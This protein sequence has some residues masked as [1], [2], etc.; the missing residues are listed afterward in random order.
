MTR[1]ARIAVWLGVAAAIAAP[2]S[3]AITG[4]GLTASQFAGQ[5]DATLR[6]AGYAF[7]I[8]GVIYAG[9]IGYAVRRMLQGPGAALEA[10]VDL[11]LA[12]ASLGCGLWIVAA[13]LN[14]RWLTVLVIAAAL[15]A[16][17]VGLVRLRRTSRTFTWAERLTVL[18]PLALLAG[19]L[20]VAAVVNLLTVLTAEGLI[21]PASASAAAIAGIVAAGALSL[22]VLRATRLV[23]YTLPVAWGLLGAFMAERGDQ[24][25][26]AYAA[27]AFAGLLPIA[28][29]FI[30]PASV[31]RSA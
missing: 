28:A 13:G 22:A 5:G 7:S 21:G 30:R 8:W 1:A 31:A 6:V 9:L 16:A 4:W 24:P 25:V 23:S 20:T 15:A 12:A 3:Q 19:W 26:V 14:L 11:P 10:A 27:L 18:W 29:I 17:L 2:A